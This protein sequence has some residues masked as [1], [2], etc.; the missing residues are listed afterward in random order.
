M[1]E[2]NGSIL[3]H[4]LVNLKKDNENKRK[5]ALFYL[6]NIKNRNIILP[7]IKK[8]SYPVWH[9]FIIMTKERDRL[10]KILLKEKFETKILYPVPIHKQ[11]AYREYKKIR[12]PL[13]EKIHSQNLSL[14]LGN[15][16][17]KTDLKKICLII[18]NFK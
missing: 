4:K 7:K 13:T 11:K 12:F 18:N 2:I 15:H 6:N 9:Q 10:R 16:Y 14:P 1:S 3:I 5:K 8:K 17:T